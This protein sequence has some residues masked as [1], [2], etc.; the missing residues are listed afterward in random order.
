M[1]IPKVK[2][3]PSGSYY[4]EMRLGGERVYVTR[5]TEKECKRDAQTIK[6]EYLSG[7]RLEPEKPKEKK[8]P[9]LGA[10][11]DEY[12]SKRTNVLSPS[13]VAGYRAI[14]RTRF[15]EYTG[16]SLS[17]MGQEEWQIACNKEAG[18]C[19]AKTLRNAWGFVAGVIQEATGKPAPKV[20]LP[21][22]VVRDMPFLEPEQIGCFIKAIHGQK[23]EIPALLGLLSL[24]RSEILG[25]RWENVDLEH[26]VIHVSG[27]SVMDE[28]YKLVHKKTNKNASSARPVPILIPELHDALERSEEKSGYVVQ[29]SA[30]SLWDMVNNVC[31]KN[32]LPLVGVHGLRRS[33]VSL[34]FHLGIPEEIIM[35]IGGW[36]DYQTMRK[37]Y[38]RIAQSD[39]KKHTEALKK[40]FS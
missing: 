40:F 19:S 10:A 26:D 21:Q 36:S 15:L 34:G 30:N 31:K 24:R 1:R 5:R 35:E 20:K 8:L 17:D 39:R 12:I 32:G 18:K 37:H 3:L 11:M 9:T 23:V 2:K 14:K 28:N 38:K 7:K 27:A 33:F 6:A 13:T 22:V 4:I 29:L 16:V 25:L